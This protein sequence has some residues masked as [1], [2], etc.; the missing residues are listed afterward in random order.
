[1]VAQI[2]P[3]PKP[4]ALRPSLIATYIRLGEAHRKLADLHAAGHFPA[5]RIVVEASR[6]RRQRDLVAVVRDAGGEVVLD[7]EVAE[8]AAL[9]R[10][11]GRA[12]G[13]PWALP[14]GEGPLGPAHFQADASADVIGQIARLA[15]A[16]RVAAVLAPAHHR[17]SSGQEGQQL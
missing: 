11:R 15:V 1:M 14:D 16:E 6:I 17:D 3:F 9:G 5:Q 4:T 7:P 2:L 12:R 8:L 10:F 13:A